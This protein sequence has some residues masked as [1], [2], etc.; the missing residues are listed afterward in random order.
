MRLYKEGNSW[1]NETVDSM[2]FEPHTLRS[3]E[4]LHAL[5]VFHDLQQ[6]LQACLLQEE[7]LS[8]LLAS[9]HHA[10]TKDGALYFIERAVPYI[11]HLENCTLLKTLTIALVEGLSNAHG[12]HML[13]YE[14]IRRI[15]ER[16]Q[17]FIE[18]VAKVMNKQILGG[19]LNVTQWKL[20]T[21]KEKGEPRK[22]GVINIENYH[23]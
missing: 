12:K 17:W 18:A 13:E 21:E 15:D 9:L 3:M 22:I 6:Q 11:L 5:Q 2:D 10:D 14:Y 7:Q 4:E 1:R 8:H 23:G 20:L 16:E 19:E